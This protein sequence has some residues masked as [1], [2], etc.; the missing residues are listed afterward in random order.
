MV[1]AADLAA[2][3]ADMAA[4]RVDIA[5]AV[6]TAVADMAAVRAD[7]TA[8]A[9]IPRAKDARMRQSAAHTPRK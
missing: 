4:V 3:A 5:L 9:S 1:A 8:D 2:M 7:I 6:T